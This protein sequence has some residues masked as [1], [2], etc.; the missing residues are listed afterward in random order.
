MINAGNAAKDGSV[1]TILYVSG[2][3]VT[4]ILIVVTGWAAIKA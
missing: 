1:R 3:L 4:V 2:A